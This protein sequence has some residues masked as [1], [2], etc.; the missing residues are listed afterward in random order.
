MSLASLRPACQQWPLREFEQKRM[1]VIW[2]I[3]VILFN[4]HEK[5]ACVTHWFPKT[6]LELKK[7]IITSFEQWVAYLNLP[8]FTCPSKISLSLDL[9]QNILTA[10]LSHTK[11]WSAI[12]QSHFSATTTFLEKGTYLFSVLA[13]SP[14]EWWEEGGKWGSLHALEN[15]ITGSNHFCKLSPEKRSSKKSQSTCF[16]LFLIYFGEHVKSYTFCFFKKIY[17]CFFL[18]IVAQMVLSLTL[19]TYK[20]IW[21]QTHCCCGGNGACLR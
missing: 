4:L 21:R 5:N 18:L 15:R 6:D 19:L 13:K 8:T 9:S 12:F 10:N 1:M 16:T 20:L 14:A 3:S 11:A 2:F 7:I 17:L